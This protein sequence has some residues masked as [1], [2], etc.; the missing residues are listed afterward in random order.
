MHQHCTMIPLLLAALVPLMEGALP[1]FIE[2]EEEGWRECDGS[3]CWWTTFHMEY[4]TD[5]KVWC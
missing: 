3:M 1:K 5:K 2:E 4:H